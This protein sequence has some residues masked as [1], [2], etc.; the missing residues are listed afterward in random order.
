MLLTYAHLV[1]PITNSR[2]YEF[3]QREVRLYRVHEAY[4]DESED[5]FHVREAATDR[6]L[7]WGETKE[8]ALSAAYFRLM[9]ES[10]KA[11]G[12][13]AAASAA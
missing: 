6:F 5:L 1:Q 10:E 11:F 2:P 12:A 9:E 3:R 8:D 4:T 7:G 13:A